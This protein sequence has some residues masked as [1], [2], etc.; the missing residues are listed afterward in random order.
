VPAPLTG[1]VPK[2]SRPTQGWTLA[3]A[4]KDPAVE[5]PIN[6]WVHRPIAFSLIRPLEHLELPVTPNL[7]TLL[8]GVAGLAAAACYYHALEGGT[9]FTLAGALLLFASVILD[10][11]DGMLAR[12]TGGGSRFGM[13]LDGF[14]DTVVGISVWYG[15][16]HTLCG[17]VHAWW[18][19]PACVL[20]LP[21]ILVHCALYDDAKNRYLR[22]VGPARAAT[23]GPTGRVERALDAV[24]RTVYGGIAAGTTA[25][26]AAARVDR[27]LARREL[28]LP[29]RL[30]GF[31]GLGSHL[32]VIYTTTLLSAI[33][34]GLALEVMAAVILFGSNA[35]MVF[36][37]A[38]WTRAWRRMG[39]S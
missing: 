19:W 20:I 1:E 35:V 39:G 3:Q 27:H 30:T 18:A 34:P 38:G 31:I 7:I 8:S 29:M 22:A 36:A 24:Y 13:L 15:V 25:P 4:L 23:P 33:D 14:V 6:R 32:V 2:L 9:A 11:A 12:L 37:L 21:T 28:A 10:C 26:R 5:E 16:S 17:Q